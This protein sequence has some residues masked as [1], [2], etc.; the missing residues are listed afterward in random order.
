MLGAECKVTD[1]G[2]QN[3]FEAAEKLGYRVIRYPLGNDALL[4]F[5]LIKILSELFFEFI[6]NIIRNIFCCSR[7][8]APK[9]T[10][11]RTR[12]DVN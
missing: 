10:F 7:N 1:Y 11:V 8:W 5:A 3:I 6:I 12:F 2:F 9:T 4:G